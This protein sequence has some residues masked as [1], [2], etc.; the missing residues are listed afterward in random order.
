MDRGRPRSQEIELSQAD[1]TE[2][3]SLA[4][5]RALPA[6]LVRRARIVL[7]SAEGASN[8]AIAQTLEISTPSVGVW[9]KRYLERGVAG[10]LL[11]R[12][13]GKTLPKQR[14]RAGR[15]RSE[16]RGEQRYGNG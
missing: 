13:E 15:S 3:K 4:R 11:E 10:T 6:A 2:L 1:R 9:R 14:E 16:A 12:G 5:S 7:M 8:R